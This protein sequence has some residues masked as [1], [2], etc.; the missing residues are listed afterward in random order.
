MSYLKVN[1]LEICNNLKGAY[2]K[3]SD[4][5]F[6]LIMKTSISIHRVMMLV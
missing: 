4:P 2:N 6:F 3:R 1:Y 5:I